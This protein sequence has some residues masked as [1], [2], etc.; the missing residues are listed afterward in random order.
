MTMSDDLRVDIEALQSAGL[1]LSQW[2]DMADQIA[3]RMEQATAQYADAGGGGEMGKAFDE[4]YKPGEGKA[5]EFLEIL[6]K[7]LGGAGQRTIQTAK[8]YDETD[9]DASR[10]VP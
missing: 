2:S 5:L 1:N 3:K 10:A 8:N 7:E 4:H 6:K 9:D